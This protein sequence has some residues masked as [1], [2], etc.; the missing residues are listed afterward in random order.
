MIDFI[1]A[2]ESDPNLNPISEFHGK[3]KCCPLKANVENVF[4]GPLF[5]RL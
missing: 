1:T 4:A 3:N 5:I 2:I